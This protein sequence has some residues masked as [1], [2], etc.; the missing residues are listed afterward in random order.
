MTIYLYS[1]TPGSG[2]SFHATR[3]IRDYLKYKKGY[4]ISN[5]NIKPDDK[6]GGKFEYAENDTIRPSMLVLRAAD[7][8][9]NTRFREESI[10]LVIDEAQ[11]VFNSRTWTEIDRLEW[12]KFFSQH[13]KYGY[14]VILIAQSSAMIDK[15]IRAVVEY[16]VEHRKLANFGGIGKFFDILF[17]GPWFLAITRYFCM[18]ERLG[19]EWVHYS[20]KIARMYNS[21]KY[22]DGTL[23]PGGA[24]ALPGREAPGLTDFEVS[25]IMQLQNVAE[26]L[27]LGSQN[28][29]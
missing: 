26:T 27:E 23:Q 9:S 11:L 10:L 4:V 16:E 17:F 14:K 24:N 21:Y 29:T 19:S 20:R 25:N 7:Y 18:T 6:W 3:D 2:K 15:Q 22:F 28:G 12:I 8:F 5:Y 13:R 1:G